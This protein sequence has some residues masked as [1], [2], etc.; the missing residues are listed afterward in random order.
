MLESQDNSTACGA[1]AVSTE[2][3][4]RAQGA[5]S[6]ESTCMTQQLDWY[7]IEVED[8]LIDARAAELL[9]V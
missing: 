6:G 8:E 9:C 3:I 7:D 1:Q 2:Q 4:T 5:G